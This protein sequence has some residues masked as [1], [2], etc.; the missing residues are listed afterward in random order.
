MPF[1]DLADDDERAVA[2]LVRSLDAAAVM[3]TMQGEAG[4][5]PTR[6]AWLRALA[7]WARAHGTL[8]VV[9]DVQLGCGRTG[10]FFSF[11]PA[12]IVADIVC[13]SKSISGHGMPMALTLMRPEYEV[14][15]PGEHNHTLLGDNPAFV[16]AAQLLEL[17]W[18]NRC[19]GGPDR[20]AG[21]TCGPR[22]V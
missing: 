2:R 21:R 12:G 18:S 5:H 20:G 15:K 16:T 11:E 14:W 1:D 17:F 6:A 8:L 19:A 3:E 7:S 10:P 13:L 4:V 22:G 9:D